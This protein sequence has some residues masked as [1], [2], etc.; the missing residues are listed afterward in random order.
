MFVD[1]RSDPPDMSS[2]THTLMF[3]SF[4]SDDDFFKWLRSK[5]ISA[6]DCKTLSG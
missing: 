1:Q 5:G 2:A 4:M 6:K 3:S